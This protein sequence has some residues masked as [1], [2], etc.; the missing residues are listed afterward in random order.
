MD[1]RADAG[2]DQEH[3]LAQVVEN[4]AES[5]LKRSGRRSSQVSS[6]AALHI[7][8]AARKTMQLRNETDAAARPTEMNALHAR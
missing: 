6:A 8:C 2:D 3:R 4:E 1:E 7:A 5:A